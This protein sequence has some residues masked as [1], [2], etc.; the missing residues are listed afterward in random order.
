M[1]QKILQIALHLLCAACIALSLV[2][3]DDDAKKLSMK[4]NSVKEDYEKLKNK[5]N[6]EQKSQNASNP[7]NAQQKPPEA[8]Q[9]TSE[10]ELIENDD[11]DS[12]MK[13][14]ERAKNSVIIVDNI[15]PDWLISRL[16]GL[17]DEH[18]FLRIYMIQST[19]RIRHNNIFFIPELKASFI[20]VDG[21]CVLFNP[22]YSVSDIG[23]SYYVCNNT[24]GTKYFTFAQNIARDHVV[25]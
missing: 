6:T 11:D 7:N 24:I 22:T 17:I 15:I 19:K 18:P 8:K 13:I 10:F 1:K 12:F 23:L 9:E 2:G 3:C 25:D 20:V 5:N 4:Q 14:F 21:A 16:D